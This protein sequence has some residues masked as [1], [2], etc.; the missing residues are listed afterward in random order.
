MDGLCYVLSAKPCFVLY[1]TC[2]D[3]YVLCY[4]FCS[5]SYKL[6]RARYEL[7]DICLLV[8]YSFLTRDYLTQPPC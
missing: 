1:D 6:S 3:L 7:Y 5:L 2:Y 8:T 4:V